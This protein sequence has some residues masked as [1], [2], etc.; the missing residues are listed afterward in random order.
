MFMASM[1]VHSGHE[2]R[3]APPA[4]FMFEW[5]NGRKKM[6]YDGRKELYIA[7]YLEISSRILLETSDESLSQMHV[8]FWWY[9]KEMFVS[10]LS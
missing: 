1:A 7:E 2:S 3:N 5:T 10:H 4:L 9:R 8:K 6:L